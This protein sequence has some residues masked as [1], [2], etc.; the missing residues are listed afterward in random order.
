[1]LRIG[2]ERLTMVIFLSAR[3][4]RG[5]DRTMSAPSIVRGVAMNEIEVRG[6]VIWMD[7][8]KKERE[9][10]RMGG[11]YYGPSQSMNMS[12]TQA[13]AAELLCL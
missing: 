6:K 4:R 5:A 7:G 1:M 3:A 12:G 10:S 8:E 13:V 2:C 11:V 9:A